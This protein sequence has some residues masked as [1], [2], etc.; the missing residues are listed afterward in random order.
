MAFSPDG[1][2]IATGNASDLVIW[3]AATGKEEFRLTDPGNRDY[4]VLSLAFSP[5]SRRII[6]GYGQFNWP[7][8]V[9][10]ANLWDLTSR[11][12]IERIPGNRGTVYSVA[13][14]PDGREV[15]LASEGLVEVCDVE[16]P[17]RPIRALRGHTGFV[18]A[19]AFSPDGRY[20]ASGGLDRTLRLW[21]RA[22][23]QEIRAFFGHEGFVRGLAFSPD[24]RWLLS[25]SEDCSLKLWEIASGRSLA[26]FHGHQ[27]F[28]SCVAFS[29]D[30]RLVAS[31]GQDHAVKLWSATQRAPLTFTGHDGAVHGLVFLPDSQRLVSGAGYRSTRGRLKLWD[32]TTGEPLEPSFESCPEIYAVAL[33]RDGR[34][35]ATACLECGRTWDRAGLGSRYRP[36]RMGTG[37]ASG[38]GHRRG[39]QPG[40]S[41]AR[42]G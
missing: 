34:R 33:H 16:T 37:G 31:G 29:P 8:D 10:H 6:A 7:S 5:D 4:P 12:L 17:T 32:A 36:A 42:L 38:R 9:G 2:W 21:D 11:K 23:G 18:Y 39:L 24:S 28:T 35:L 27:S 14:S 3:D 41:V 30:G 15:A 26:D 40:R 25:A 13:F 22:T 1:R 19:V 20:L